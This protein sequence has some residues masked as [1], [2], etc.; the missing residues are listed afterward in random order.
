LGKMAV[1]DARR[2]WRRNKT[3]PPDIPM[4]DLPSIGW[5]PVGATRRLLDQH[6]SHRGHPRGRNQPRTGRGIL[7]TVDRALCPGL[8]RPAPG[9][10]FFALLPGGIRAGGPACRASGDVFSGG[11]VAAAD[12]SSAE[13]V[14]GANLLVLAITRPHVLCGSSG[15]SDIHFSG[16]LCWAVVAG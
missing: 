7:L 16:L 1:V 14:F 11:W 2:A 8:I 5:G 9:P 12:S 15:K 10:R 4:Q 6:R 13:L 3:R